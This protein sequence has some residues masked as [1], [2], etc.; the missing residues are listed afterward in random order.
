MTLNQ[1]VGTPTEA[2]SGEITRI[3]NELATATA[4][5]E[6]AVNRL[7]DELQPIRA[8]ETMADKTAQPLAPPATVPLG[9]KLQKVLACANS[10][11]TRLNEILEQLQL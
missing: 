1:D 9:Q 7:A 2:P 10:T 3:A 5:V 4:G 8:A 11:Q 6:A